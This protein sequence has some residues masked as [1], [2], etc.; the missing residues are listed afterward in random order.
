MCAFLSQPHRHL[1]SREHNGWMWIAEIAVIVYLQI[2]GRTKH[3]SPLKLPTKNSAR[4]S[5]PG[6]GLGSGSGGGLRQQEVEAGKRA[7][8]DFWYEEK[9]MWTQGLAKL[10]FQ[11]PLPACRGGTFVFWKSWVKPQY[12][13]IEAP[14]RVLMLPLPELTEE[15]PSFRQSSASSPAPPRAVQEQAPIQTG[16]VLKPARIQVWVWISNAPSLLNTPLRLVSDSQHQ[17]Q[18]CRKSKSNTRVTGMI[19]AFVNFNSESATRK[20]TWEKLGAIT[21]QVALDFKF[22]CVKSQFSSR[23][24]LLEG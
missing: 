9:Q 4:L 15:S 10:P 22:L 13:R 12:C 6:E 2:I 1:L 17:K 16:P 20:K 24:N 5:Q 23:L 21:Q 11:A 18:H 7:G 8:G 3:Q 14:E 19:V